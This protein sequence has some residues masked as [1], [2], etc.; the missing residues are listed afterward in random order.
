MK[1]QA[2]DDGLGEEDLEEE[3]APPFYRRPRFWRVAIPLSITLSAATAGLLLTLVP[4]FHFYTT[5][6]ASEQVGRHA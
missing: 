3:E 6:S 5:V 2:S 1:S 4:S